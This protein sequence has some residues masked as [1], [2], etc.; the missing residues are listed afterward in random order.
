VDP[1][2][3]VWSYDF[4]ASTVTVGRICE[5][6]ALGYFAEGSMRE[7][8]EEVF[9]DPTDDEAVVFEFFTVGP[10]MLPQPVLTDTLVKFWVQ[11]HQLTLNAFAQLSMYFWAVMSFSGKPSSDCFVKRYEL[12][13]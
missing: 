1:R 5:L 13:Y 11:L 6:E 8:G 12:H 2:E 10:Q 3:S 9:P 7:P 4:G